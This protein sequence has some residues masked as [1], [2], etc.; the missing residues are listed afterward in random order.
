MNL[1]KIHFYCARKDLK[2]EGYWNSQQLLIDVYNVRNW[3]SEELTQGS[4]DWDR[5]GIMDEIAFKP[6]VYLNK[7][8]D[9]MVKNV[10]H[11]DDNPS[12][13]PNSTW[14]IGKKKMVMECYF[15]PDYM[16]YE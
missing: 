3:T 15:V 6:I 10:V 5:N 13:D 4:E 12:F 9:Y 7:D 1:N 16:V 2:L 14:I 11:D 8:Y